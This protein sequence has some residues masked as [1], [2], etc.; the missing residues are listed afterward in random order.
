MK[1]SV[2]NT[3]KKAFIRWFLKR[4][5]MKRRECVWILNYIVGHDDLLERIHFVEEA[6][7]CPRAMVMSTTDS[8]GIPFRFY[9]GNI[10]TADAE[11][12]FHDLRLNPNE[13]MYIQVNFPKLPPNS[14]YLAVLEDNPHIPKYLQSN[15]GDREVAEQ[16][17]DA[18]IMNFQKESLLRQIDEAI[19][20]GNKERFL[21]LTNELNQLNA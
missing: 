15:F 20:E 5:D 3:E 19:D 9:K 12:S 7:F 6:H 4:Y 1:T 8:S 17:L 18:S 10:M 13:D 16:L 21:E 11:K 14:N 2:T